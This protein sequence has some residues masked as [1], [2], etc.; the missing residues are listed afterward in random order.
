MKGANLNRRAFLTLGSLVT[1]A[2]WM[3]LAVSPAKAQVAILSNLTHPNI[4]LEPGD[5]EEDRIVGAIPGGD[6]WVNVNGTWFFQGNT[7]GNGN[8]S[9]TYLEDDSTV[10]TYEEHWYV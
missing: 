4:S 2:L 7:D 1:V 5:I 6:V 8:F 10:N 9:E 3:S